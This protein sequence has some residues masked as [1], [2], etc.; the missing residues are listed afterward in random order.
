MTARSAERETF[1]ADIVVTAVEGGISYWARV[2]GY[3]WYSPDTVGGSAEPSPAG[4]GNAY[5]TVYEMDDDAEPVAEYKL[6]IDTIAHAFTVVKRPE[7]RISDSLRK[8]YTA[9]SFGGDD[10]DYDASDADNLVQL[11]LF[12]E[13]VYG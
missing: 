9:L 4:G 12:E 8:R 10:V 3:R 1:L 7:T 6:T 11:G 2:G 5:C 13:L